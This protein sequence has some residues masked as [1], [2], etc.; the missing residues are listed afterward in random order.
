VLVLNRVPTA[1]RLR[2]AVEADIAAR[3][4]P[5]LVQAL[6]N[7]TAFAS[8]FAEGLGVTEAAGRSVAAS[9]LRALA[10]QICRET[11]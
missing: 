3:S 9:E 2:E 1:S 5:M 10:A 11:G 7:R 8:A 6:G 4:L